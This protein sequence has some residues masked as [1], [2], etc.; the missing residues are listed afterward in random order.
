MP[1][2]YSAHNKSKLRAFMNVVTRFFF[3]WFEK[4]E[5]VSLAE[6]LFRQILVVVHTRTMSVFRMYCV[7]C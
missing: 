3:L 4:Q 5:T 2:I 1:L 6:L 7:E